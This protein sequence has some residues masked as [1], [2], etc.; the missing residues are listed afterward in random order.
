MAL[1]FLEI[2]GWRIPVLD[3]SPSKNYEIIGDSSRAFSG[4]RRSTRR[5]IKRRFPGTLVRKDRST[6]VA[7]QLAILGFGDQWPFDYDDEADGDTRLTE[8]HFT[9]KGSG[10]ASSTDGALLFGI[11]ADK[12][13]VEDIT[14]V[15]EAQ[16][17]SGASAAG[18]DA[19]T[20][21]LPADVRDVE[22]GSTAGF[23]AVAGGA[24][25]LNTDNVLQGLQSLRV[26]TSALGDGAGTDF[27][28]ASAATEYV[29]VVYVKPA[30][31]NEANVITVSLEDD[32]GGTL[33]E[34]EPDQSPQNG[35]WVK[36][37]LVGTT[38]AAATQI[39][40]RAVGDAA[41]LVFYLDA[42]MIAVGDADAAVWV[43]GARAA[44]PL[45]VY[46]ATFINDAVDLTIN[47]WAKGTVAAP[48]ATRTGL[49]IA[50]DPAAS[51]LTGVILERISGATRWRFR[52]FLDGVQDN[53][54]G[55]NGAFDA[56]WHMFTFVIRKKLL[57]GE[58]NKAIYQDGVLDTSIV[59]SDSLPDFSRM[60]ELE[61]GHF[62]S[63]T[64]F[65]EDHEG[66]MDDLRVVPYA[67]P[68]AQI[69]GWF[70]SG[71]ALGRLPRIKATGDFIESDVPI[72]VEGENPT[73]PYRSFTDGS[74]V[75]HNAAQEVN[76][77][78]VEV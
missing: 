20:N 30:F 57:T 16:F 3:E 76:F 43:D 58:V 4:R 61:I 55:S 18:V 6:A 7:F 28:A 52:T 75:H 38:G 68:A 27:I 73:N 11:G 2:D 54:L 74:G 1:K 53:L 10:L 25:A 78:L 39:K 48:P 69:A 32:D 67:A 59:T 42:F 47:F 77:T 65:F 17:G 44:Q 23:S 22:G 19:A 15:Q 33:V 51:S 66:V 56:A 26:A 37:V 41:A 45:P 21:L 70:S 35:K 62:N 63:T 34:V 24:I 49:T 12:A 60:A 14:G 29:G 36:I 40:I 46:S 8:D 13:L 72:L 64:P 5:A 50:E 71:E 9:S 31:D